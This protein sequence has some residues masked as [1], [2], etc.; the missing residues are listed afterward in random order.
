MDPPRDVAGY[1][2]WETKSDCTWDGSAAER[3]LE[4][5]SLYLCHI[6]G[7][8]SGHPLTPNPW[9]RDFLATLFG[10]IR[11]DGTRRYREFFVG[12]PRKNNKTTMCAGL[13]L[14]LTL[15]DGEP[16]AQTYL[17]A[18]GIQQASLL[19]RPAAAMVRSNDDLSSMCQLYRQDKRIVCQSTNSFIR[20][21]PA[22]ASGLHGLNSH[23]VIID[24]IHAQPNRDL[25]DVLKTSTVARLQP[26]LGSITTAGHDQDSICYELW[27][28]ARQVRDGAISD[29]Y[30]LPVI[31]EATDND[32]WTSPDVWERVNPN[33]GR[34]V[35]PEY[36]REVFF[37]AQTVP[38]FE[39]T[40]KNLH[41]NMWTES[42]S[43]WL[44]SDAWASCGGEYPAGNALDYLSGRP[45]IAGLDLASTDDLCALVYVFPVGGRYYVLSHFFCPA[46]TIS[47]TQK[48]YQGQYRQWKQ[49]G[50]MTAT[51]GSATDYE[52][53]RERIRIDSQRYQ[54]TRIA[55]DPWQALDTQQR[56]ANMGIE[57][58]KISQNHA[59]LWPGTK[60]V[61]EAVLNRNL[62][63]DKNP[64]LDW[65]IASTVIEIDG[66]G[67]RKPSKKRSHGDRGTKG[68]I[69]GV[70]ALVM[71]MGL[72]VVDSD[73]V[74]DERGVIQM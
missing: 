21:I 3:V 67:N 11:P 73:N 15:C 45:C 69:D 31:Y 50:H 60:A 23:A 44:S 5:F 14:Y 17:A 38:A 64:C 19:Y 52:F 42:E 71:A 56:L 18:S 59:G 40:F 6:E 43:R 22:E 9:E 20:T 10:W 46:E 33:W 13:A 39:N 49:D 51:P 34:S 68:K 12:I 54:I 26:V 70:V 8:L 35:P 65:Q 24:E 32:D 61:E 48:K 4:F 16:G 63:H 7:K 1:D 37:R 62:L 28:Y 55:F 66:A 27:N 57:C 30:F 36:I 53:I 58:V 72:A 2:P 41:L 74:Y 25:Y 47:M 29:P